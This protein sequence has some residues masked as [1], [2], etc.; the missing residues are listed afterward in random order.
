MV[1]PNLPTPHICFGPFGNTWFMDVSLGTR[2]MNRK[3]ASSRHASSPQFCTDREGSN[4]SACHKSCPLC[5]DSREESGDAANIKT[6]GQQICT[7][8][9][10]PKWFVLWCVQVVVQMQWWEKRM[11]IRTP[12]K[13]VNAPTVS[14]AT[15][16]SPIIKENNKHCAAVTGMW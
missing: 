14:L 15:N 6:A 4:L 7:I 16:K 5:C 13:A 10:F 1:F 12:S 8:G 3:R 2:D 9:A 11:I